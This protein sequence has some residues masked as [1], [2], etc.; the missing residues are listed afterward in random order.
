MEHEEDLGPVASHHGDDASVGHMLR[1]AREAAGLSRGDIAAQT[2]IAERHLEAIEQDRFGD[3]AAPT[4]AVG[5]SRA[6]ARQLGLD[7]VDVAH[8][9]RVELDA[10]HARQAPP[11]PPRFEPGDPARVPSR[12]IAWMAIAAV[13]VVL[14]VLVI[15]WSQFLSPEG[16][17]PDLT[18]NTPKATASAPV[19]AAPGPAVQVAP[20]GP[21]VLTAIQPRVWVKV[22]DAG[23]KQLLQKELSQGESWTVP[24]DAQGPMLRVGRANG[25]KITVGT[26]QMPPLSDQ[27]VVMSGISLT[28]AD[29]AA[30]AKGQNPAVAASANPAPQNGAPAASPTRSVPPQPSAASTRMRPASGNGARSGAHRQTAASDSTPVGTDTAVPMVSHPV[31]QPLPQNSQR[32]DLDN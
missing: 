3:L 26:Q 30:R 18:S 5:F 6:Y 1:R 13:V 19:A 31:I 23:G 16:E 2:K 11:P 27:A 29:L 17:L 14:G 24:A 12:G 25:L 8:R 4:Y 21:V 20:S 9:V 22:T 10:Q 32:G 15:F 28:P 7:E